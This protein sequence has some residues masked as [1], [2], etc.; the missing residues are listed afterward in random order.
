MFALFVSATAL[1]GVGIRSIRPRA[2]AAHMGG[3]VLQP[4]PRSPPA[5]ESLSTA[6]FASDGIDALPALVVF[7]LDNTLWTPEL[8]T[9]RRLRADEQPT[10]WEDCWLLDGAVAALHELMSSSQW[11]KSAVAVASRTNKGT[12]AHALLDTFSL[13]TAGGGR[14]PLGDLISFREIYTGSKTTHFAKLR[15]KSGVAYEDML[16]FDDARDGRYGNCEAVSKLGVMSVHTPGGL[17][18]ELW[19]QGLEAFA[20]RKASGEPMGRIVDGEGSGRGRRAAVEGSAVEGVVRKWFNEKRF[21]FVQPSGGGADVFF[22]SSAVEGGLQPRPG[23]AVSFGVGSD[24]KGRAACT[25]LRAAAP[26]GALPTSGVSDGLGGRCVQLRA[27]S[28]NQPFAGLVA[29]GQKT[30]ET[31]NHTMFEGS[32]GERVLLHVGQ[33]TYPDGGKHL[34]ILRRAGVDEREIARL[35]SLPQGFARGQLVAILELGATELLDRE[36]RCAH[37]VEHGACAYG[38]DMGRYVTQV[39]RAEW[40]RK[41]VPMRGRPGLFQAE[42]PETALP[43]GWEGPPEGARGDSLGA[44]EAEG[45]GEEATVVFEFEL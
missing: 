22:H 14:Q 27:F 11:A 7:D 20:Q 45:E 15:E 5:Y 17:T 32:E 24:A 2:S 43:E 19:R 34:D 33:R 1:V 42:V 39:V 29:H 16:F 23:L 36:A 25:Y 38:D 31:R 40:L 26:V 21:G 18:R 8:Y 12:W 4:R 35:T 30:L 44:A 6:T 28:M 9:L 10:P 13:P 41:P 37:D 3:G